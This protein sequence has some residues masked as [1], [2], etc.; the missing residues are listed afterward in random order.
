MQLS[1]QYDWGVK[2]DSEFFLSKSYINPFEKNSPKKTKEERFNK[3]EEDFEQILE[4]TY[5]SL[6]RLLIF[7]LD[8]PIQYFH[9]I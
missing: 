4:K 2:G 6:F 1:F 3:P 8:L 9:L 7:L 5:K